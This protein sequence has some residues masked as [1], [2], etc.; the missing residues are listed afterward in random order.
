MNTTEAFW[1]AVAQFSSGRDFVFTADGQPVLGGDPVDSFLHAVF[2]G[3]V[4]PTHAAA[5]KWEAARRIEAAGFT[6]HAQANWQRYSLRLLRKRADGIELTADEQAD[7]AFAEQADNWINA[8]RLASD[9]IE[10]FETNPFAEDAPWPAAPD[11][12]NMRAC[13]KPT[14]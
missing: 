7:A 8:V 12:A 1:S 9:L 3:A 13:P 11:P 6:T 10:Q 4:T 14:A 2:S 5:V